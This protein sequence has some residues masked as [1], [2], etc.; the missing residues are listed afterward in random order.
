[1]NSE[2]FNFRAFSIYQHENVMKVNT[3]GVLLG[4]FSSEKPWVNVLEVGCGLGY[5]SLMLTQMGSK[6]IT[7]IDINPYAVEI[8]KKNFELSP[9][10]NELEVQH[11]SLN[12]WLLTNHEKL[13][14]IVTNP[15]Y[16]TNAF[17]SPDQNKRISR[18][19][20]KKWIK[21][22]IEASRLLT[23]DGQIHL[24]YPY[25]Q[26]FDIEKKFFLHGLYLTR[27]WIVRSLP[28]VEPY[29]RIMAFT[30]K[31]STV[32]NTQKIVIRKDTSTYTDEYRNLV[33]AFLYI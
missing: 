8:T 26:S 1:M 29:L 7:A 2:V 21:E 10:K 28:N 27:Q 5:I 31:K 9:W 22:L 24:I 30:Q 14:L 18:H 6:K 19:T 4:V 25:F 32:V 12:D 17:P 11:I 15:P 13:N 23:E 20:E 16:F 33:G 3:D